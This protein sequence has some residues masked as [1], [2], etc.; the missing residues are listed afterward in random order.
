MRLQL[1]DMPDRLRC[2]EIVPGDVF[3][4]QKGALMVVVAVKDTGDVCLMMF[5]ER[6]SITG[7]QKYAQ[8]YLLEKQR[9]GR[10]T[11]LPEALEV[12]WEVE[13]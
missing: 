3:R 1:S 10:V 7:V 13:V 11:N 6:G 9:L 2:R 5:S 4:N 8:H 12:D